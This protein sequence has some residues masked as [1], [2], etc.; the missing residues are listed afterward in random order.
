MTAADVTRSAESAYGSTAVEAGI[1]PADSHP[2]PSAS[3]PAAIGPLLN[4]QH[5]IA[6]APSPQPQTFNHA[7]LPRRQDLMPGSPT[8]AGATSGPITNAPPPSDGTYYPILGTLDLLEPSL[9]VI[10]NP[11]TLGEVSMVP[12]G[13]YVGDQLAGSKGNSSS[14]LGDDLAGSVGNSSTDP[15]GLRQEPGMAASDDMAGRGAKRSATLVP[16]RLFS[17]AVIYPY[18]SRGLS[19]QGADLSVLSSTAGAPTYCLDIRG[20]ATDEGAEV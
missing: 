10:S 20:V 8:P 13:G 18:A 7:D 14:S 2:R 4:S 12:K 17:K 15:G 1:A 11:A 16:V 6:A 3:A 9:D 19:C 5:A